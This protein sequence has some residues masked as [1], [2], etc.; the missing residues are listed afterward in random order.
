MSAREDE[1]RLYLE[2]M[3]RLAPPGLALRDARLALELARAHGLRVEEA[4]A[5]LGCG[6]GRHLK[7]L[8]ALGVRGAIGVDR[9]AL[10]LDA[11]AGE[12]PAAR[13][14]RA[15]LCALPLRSGCLGG[16]FC[17]Y[18][19]MFLGT[20]EEALQALREAARAL[21]PGAPLVLTTDNPL[22]LAASPAASWAED[23]AGLG[24]V[25]EESAFDA[26]SGVD[27]VR[28]TLARRGGGRL[29][30]TFRIRYFRPPELAA[31]ADAA[32]LAFVRLEPDAPLAEGTP[33]V[34]ALLA[35][36]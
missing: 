22:R 24:R 20:R 4:L 7:A 31:L 9:S 29:E 19:S 32:G 34:V 2:T 1:E 6:Y 17:F 5:D 25:E 13:L 8:E 14:V 15:D 16:G 28:R 35:R 18:S 12:A 33:Q 23:V 30:A 21:R 36:R 26:A 11:A 10:L 3:R 27:V